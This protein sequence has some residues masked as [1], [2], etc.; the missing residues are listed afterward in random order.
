MEMK[1]ENDEFTERARLV[2]IVTL[3]RVKDQVC[4]D[5]IDSV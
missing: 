1:G 3:R 2:T 4:D 5:K